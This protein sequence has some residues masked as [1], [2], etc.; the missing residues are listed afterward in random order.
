MYDFV[1]FGQSQFE[2]LVTNIN[3][4]NSP[5]LAPLVSMSER[6]CN[7]E[8]IPDI[9]WDDM[10]WNHSGNTYEIL[11]MDMGEICTHKTVEAVT[12]PLY[13]NFDLALKTCAKLG[14]G[15]ITSYETPHN[16]SQVNFYQLYGKHY[17][18]FK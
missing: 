14:N 12:L 5:V 13:Y 1:T 8:L 10:M 6:I 3:I 17:K 7:E 4:F 2:G 15:K 16:L 18:V 11:D 9:S